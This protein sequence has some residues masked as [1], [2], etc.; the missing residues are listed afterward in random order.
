MKTRCE[1]C[2]GYGRLAD[3]PCTSCDGTG[4]VE[5]C[6]TCESAPRDPLFA[7]ACSGRCRDAWEIEQR[8]GRL[9]MQSNA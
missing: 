9:R 6:V 8:L 4:L 2:A 3:H 5:A 1:R 7:P